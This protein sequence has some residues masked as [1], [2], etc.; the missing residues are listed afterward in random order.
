M[1]LFKFLKKKTILRSIVFSLFTGLDTLVIPV[2]VNSIIDSVQKSDIP[3]LFFSSLYGMIGFI[4]LQ[5]SLFFWKKNLAKLNQEFSTIAKL[6]TFQ[7]AIDNNV[8][9][10][11]IENI[12]YNDIPVIEK[13]YLEAYLQFIYC[14]WFSLVSFI[15]VLSLSW[16]VSILF[17]TFSVIPLLLPKLF[18]KKLKESNIK[19]SDSNKEF[20]KEVNESL[21]GI[22]VMRH[23]E[24]IPYLV[25]RFLG[26]LSIRENS[27]YE[28][29]SLSFKVNLI[30]NIFAIISGILP[31]GLGGYL[32][33]KGHLSVGALIAVFL[34]SDRVLSPLE[35]AISHWN[36]VKSTS[37]LVEKLG[38]IFIETDPSKY[39]K[40]K[41]SL[42]TESCEIVF[43]NV[44]FGYIEP[45]FNLTTKLEVGKKV[46]ITGASGSGKTTIFK[47]LFKEIEKLSGFLSINGKEIDRI[48]QGFLYHNIGYIPQ[49]IIIF[50]DSLLFNITLGEEFS[51]SQLQK[52]IAQSGLKKLVEEKGL[53]YRLGVQGENI[54]GGE[55]ARI[56]V[57]RSLL[58]DYSVILVDEFSSALDHQT[59]SKIRDIFLSI[60]ATI[61]EIAHHY[62]DQDKLKYDEIWELGV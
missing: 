29:N 20:V 32:A 33:I 56:V 49:N 34:A 19:W 57:A 11:Y 14:I 37:P 43:E 5:F 25:S 21:A 24:R 36:N 44:H 55:R 41:E 2:I 39:S 46:L 59:A 12:I 26:K 40:S 60:D 47:T 1:I 45:L 42:S 23:Y 51:A 4:L 58:R 10:D 15:Y 53:D 18:E 35:N 48:E 31:F 61:I 9:D 38:D 27:D 7:Y 52:V 3:H 62:S 30:I 50:D 54:S 13:Q 16:Q 22:S 28:K 8:P 17:V 6:K